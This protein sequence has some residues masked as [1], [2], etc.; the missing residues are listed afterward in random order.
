MA[1]ESGEKVNSSIKEL[2]KI[3]SGSSEATAAPSKENGDGAA[4]LHV[5]RVVLILP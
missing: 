2:L 3:E 4:V 1:Q 5:R